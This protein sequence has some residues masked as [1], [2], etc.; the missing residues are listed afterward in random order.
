VQLDPWTGNVT[1]LP[2]YSIAEG[3][4]TFPV[5][6]QSLQSTL[7]TVVPVSHDILHAINTTVESLVRDESGQQ[8]IAHSTT[9]GTFQTQFQDGTSETLTLDDPGEAIELSNWTLV[10]DDWQPADGNATSGDVTATNKIRHQ[11]QLQSYYLGH[12]FLNSSKRL[13]TLHTLQTLLLIH[14]R[15]PQATMSS[16]Q[17]LMARSA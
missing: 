17:S 8:L 15:I 12:P 7:I 14:E 10:I 3:R 9:G 5:Q 6:L 1:I 11:I 13:E 2:L 16:L 4:L